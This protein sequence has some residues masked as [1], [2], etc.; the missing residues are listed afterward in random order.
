[1]TP[2]PGGTFAY[3]FFS[4]DG[5]FLA[6]AGGPDHKS[7]IYV[8]NA[9]TGKHMTTITV[10]NS[11]QAYPLTFTPNEKWLI[12]VDGHTDSSGNRTLYEF[13]I[14]NAK[15][16]GYVQ[17][18]GAT[19]AVDNGGDVEANETRDGRHI[20]IYDLTSGHNY[21][22]HEYN[23]PTTASTVP[24]SLN[25]SAD[26][27]RMLISDVNG[28]AYVMDTT[29]GQ[30]LA[31]FNYPYVA[32]PTSQQ[33]PQLSPDGKT[34]Y[35]PGGSNAPGQLWSVDSGTN[36][37]PSNSL[38]PQKNGWVIYSTDGQ[39]VVTS[40]AGSPT[41]DLWNVSAGTHTTTSTIPGSG[42]WVVEALGP[43]G[44]E[45]LF[46]SNPVDKSDDTKQAYVYSIP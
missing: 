4:P 34:V 44:S 37:T 39:D 40:A 41:V 15:V 11:G 24:N 23:N 35:T 45:V 42:D 33:L 2:P 17:E 16:I 10:P 28:K 46:G 26:G 22:V 27:S 7:D 6:L 18:P 32:N 29:S 20:D 21:P 3:G 43:S 5:R 25:V 9:A 38:W 30:T 36:V 14:T 12:A 8:Y 13:D 31:T 1:L 19:Y